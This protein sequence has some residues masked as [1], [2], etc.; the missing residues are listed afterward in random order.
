[1]AFLFKRRAP[2]IFSLLPVKFSSDL[3]KPV[4]KTYMNKNDENETGMDRVKRMFSSE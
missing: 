1:M 3:D 2:Y 4:I